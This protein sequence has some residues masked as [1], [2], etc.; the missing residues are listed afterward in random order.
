M[1]TEVCHTTKVEGSL[2]YNSRLVL[3]LK[4]DNIFEKSTY[5]VA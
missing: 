3:K 1:V 4:Y 5:K 2:N